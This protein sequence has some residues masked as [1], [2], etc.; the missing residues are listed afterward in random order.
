MGK[1]SE[2]GHFKAVK[3]ALSQFTNT[4]PEVLWLAVSTKINAPK[5]RDWANGRVI[6]GSWNAKVT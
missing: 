3:G 5:M 4:A 6:R 1:V 2:S